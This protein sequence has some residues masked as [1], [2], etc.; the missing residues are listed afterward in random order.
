MELIKEIK[1]CRLCEDELPKAPHPVFVLNPKSPFLIVGQAPGL[2]V[3]ETG[4]PWNDA[5]GERLR[6]WLGIP[7]SS[8][9]NSSMFSIVPIGLCYPGRGKSGDLPP[10]KECSVLWMDTIL[11][12]FE[13]L[14]KLILVGSYSSQYFL[15]AGEISVKIREHA[16]NDSPFIVLPHP[17]PRNNIWL[18]RNEWFENESIPLIRKKLSLSLP[19]TLK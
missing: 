1:A 2:K 12:E 10:R 11:C 18:K 16:T 19:R 13:N 3:H 14:K 15:G 4:I 8:F 17:S 5:S 9:Y 7:A 6:H